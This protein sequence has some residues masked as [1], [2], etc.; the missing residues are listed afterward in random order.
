MLNLCDT[1]LSKIEGDLGISII[2]SVEGLSIEVSCKVVS[3][4]VDLL[5]S[6]EETLGGRDIINISQSK[7]ILVFSVSEGLVVNIKQAILG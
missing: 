4:N 6:S 3:D 7:D 1:S 5:P 2:L